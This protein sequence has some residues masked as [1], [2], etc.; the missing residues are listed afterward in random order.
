MSKK[1]IFRMWESGWEGQNRTLSIPL[2]EEIVEEFR[3]GLAFVGDE[4]MSSFSKEY[5]FDGMEVISYGAFEDVLT[6]S[7]VLSNHFD[8]AV[9]EPGDRLSE[10]TE[11]LN[12][13]VKV[14]FKSGPKIG[15]EVAVDGYEFSLEGSLTKEKFEDMAS[16]LDR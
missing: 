3:S 7:E 11:P 15:L 13:D 14:T 2:T 5:A 9:A 10:D 4:G 1:M 16:W 12:R 6:E 8:F